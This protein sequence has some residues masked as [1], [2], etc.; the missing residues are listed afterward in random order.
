MFAIKKQ[1]HLYVSHMFFLATDQ[2]IEIIN[3]EIC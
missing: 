1:V 2:K 3:I